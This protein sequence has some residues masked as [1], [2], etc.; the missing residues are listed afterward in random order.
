MISPVTMVGDENSP[1]EV[2]ITRNA[3]S[4]F[5][6]AY[7][8][9]IYSDYARS[10]NYDEFRKE[11]KKDSEHY[12]DFYATEQPAVC[13]RECAEVNIIVSYIIDNSIDIIRTFILKFCLNHNLNI[14]SDIFKEFYN[15][16]VSKVFDNIF[17]NDN[18]KV[19]FSIYKK[20]YN[21]DNL[22]LF[23]DTLSDRIANNITSL[24]NNF[25]TKEVFESLQNDP[26]ENS[27]KL[28]EN[29]NR[30]LYSIREDLS[31]GI[32]YVT[33]AIGYVIRTAV[34]MFNLSHTKEKYNAESMEEYCRKDPLLIDLVNMYYEVGYNN[35]EK[36]N[37]N[38]ED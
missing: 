30:L 7:E 1:Y 28:V 33:N 12:K 18:M 16:D 17:D 11:T 3:N 14:K 25:I 31:D 37:N 20:S 9:M 38:G 15:E 22:Y 34:N 23:L 32:L 5:T 26:V 29:Y 6:L 19:I 4:I 21:R 27:D 36:E 8:S 24:L 2:G 10:T 13:T 35:K